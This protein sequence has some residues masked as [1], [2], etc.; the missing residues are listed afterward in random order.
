MKRKTKKNPGL[1][2]LSLMGMNIWAR[3]DTDNVRS[4]MIRYVFRFRGSNESLWSL[5]HVFVPDLP[6][7]CPSWAHDYYWITMMSSALRLAAL[8]SK[9]MGGET[10]ASRS[11]H[12]T[13]SWPGWSASRLMATRSRSRRCAGLQGYACAYVFASY[14]PY[15]VLGKL[16]RTYMFGGGE[17]SSDRSAHWIALP[18]PVHVAL[19]HISTLFKEVCISARLCPCVCFCMRMPIHAVCCSWYISPYVPLSLREER[20]Q[21][22]R[23]THQIWYCP[24]WCASPL[25]TFR[26]RSCLQGFAYAYILRMSVHN[27]A[28]TCL[29]VALCLPEGRL[30]PLC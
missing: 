9:P 17:A 4:C 20:L 28:S 23:L 1:L 29:S 25:T 2:F 10:S 8:H 12:R 19:E 26:P 11:A 21:P 18:L 3:Q 6:Y 14:M 13:W 27:A 15:V 16:V 5:I 22:Y 7:S 30:P 24:C